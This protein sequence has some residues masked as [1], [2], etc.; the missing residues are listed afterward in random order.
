MKKGFYTILVLFTVLIGQA[1][2][3]TNATTIYS[4]ENELLVIP[5]FNQV[6]PICQGASLGPL[7]NVSLDGITGSWS[8]QVSNTVTTTY[9]FTPDNGQEAT[10]VT[11][12]I[13][14]LPLANPQP[15]CDYSNSFLIIDWAQVP[16]A[17]SYAY[18]YSING[19]AVQSGTTSISN[20]P[21]VSVQSNAA[22]VFTITN[23]VGVSCFQPITLTCGE[24]ATPIFNELSFNFSP[25]PVAD[26]LKVSCAKPLTYIEVY[27]ELGQKLYGTAP[28]EKEVILDMSAFNSGIYLVKAHADNASKS[29]K[30]LKN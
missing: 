18:S 4:K 17:T 22:V 21:L 25:N 1:N 29:F 19:G 6:A 5:I 26:Q 2:P 9:T 30:V 27:N 12:T 20:L 10:S 24:L 28:N 8:P 23:I 14:V 3:L 15:F 7:P 13:E 11:M 16:G